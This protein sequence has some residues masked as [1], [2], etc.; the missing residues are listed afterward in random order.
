MRKLVILKSLVDFIWIVTCIPLLLIIPVFLVM[1]FVSPDLMYITGIEVKEL[2]KSQMNYAIFYVI[3][4]AFVIYLGMYC[5]YVFRKTLRYFQQV[6]PFHKDVIS[7]FH[8]IGWLLSILGVMGSIGFFL[9]HIFLKHQIKLNLGFS[10]YLTI[11][12][13]GLFFMVLSELFKVAKTAKDENELT[14]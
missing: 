4:M 7:N 9:G 14:I 5:F 11:I 1:M 3:L 6:K 8:K 10:P 2:S 13:L 12:C